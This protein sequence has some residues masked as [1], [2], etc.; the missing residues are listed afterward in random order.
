VEWWGKRDDMADILRQAQIACLPSYYGEG[1]P[2]F[3]LEA[4]ATGLPIVTT[5][6]PGCRETVIR[7]IN[8]LIVPPRDSGA[9][10]DALNTLLRDPKR[11]YAMGRSSRELAEAEF[12]VDRVTSETLALYRKSFS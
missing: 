10:A 1:L 2:K 4:A 12:S 9:L 6:S 11:R 3:L 8:G 5:D 7:N